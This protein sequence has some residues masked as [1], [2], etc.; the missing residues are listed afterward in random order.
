MAA[1]YRSSRRVEFG[2][3]DTAGIMH[4]A[5][6]FNFMEEVEH[7]FLRSRGLSVVMTHEGRRIGW[8]RVSA[9]CDFTK[10]ARFE[11]VIQVELTLSKVGERALTYLFEFLLGSEVIARG[12][13]TTCC[14]LVGPDEIRSIPLPAD[15]RAKLPSGDD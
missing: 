13:L 7:E 4:F 6:F 10:P 9:K 11:D 15:L 12:E 2:D 1:T 5:K 3:T 14:C 8:P